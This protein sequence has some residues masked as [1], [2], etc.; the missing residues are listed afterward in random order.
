MNRNSVP[1]LEGVE[2]RFIDVGGGVTNHAADAGGSIAR[3]L[4]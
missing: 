3:T 1:P 4:R 2:H